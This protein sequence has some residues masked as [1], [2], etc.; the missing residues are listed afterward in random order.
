VAGALGAQQKSVKI[1]LR[2]WGSDVRIVPGA[3]AKS[4]ISCVFCSENL[5]INRARAD[6]GQNAR[7]A[8]AERR[9][10]QG[11]LLAALIRGRHGRGWLAR[12][13]SQPASPNGLVGKLGIWRDR[14]GGVVVHPRPAAFRVPDDMHMRLPATL[15]SAGWSSLV[16]ACFSPFV[17]RR[18]TAAANRRMTKMG[19]AR[20]FTEFEINAEQRLEV[21][22]ER[23]VRVPAVRAG[24][25]GVSRTADKTTPVNSSEIRV[26]LRLGPDASESAGA[27]GLRRAVADLRGIRP[28]RN[29]LPHRARA[30]CR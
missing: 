6:H 9:N 18:R 14:C 17:R 11:G 19:S 20:A 23:M 25:M 26:S 13:A 28:R 2:I 24:T 29:D 30:A 21:A 8:H 1:R 4:G 22:T 10:G 16:A 7:A 27:P 5:P 3:P 12:L 15:A